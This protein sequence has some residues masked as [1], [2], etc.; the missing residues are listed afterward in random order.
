[1]DIT[2][3]LGFPYLMPN[4]AQKH[5]TLNS[6]LTQLDAIIGLALRSRTLTLQPEAPAPGDTYLLP[7]GAEGTEWESV[8]PGNLVIFRGDAWMP[9]PAPAGL[10]AWVEDEGE[11][12][13]RS[14]GGWVPVIPSELPVL[15]IQTSADETN[16]L[17]V[18]S[19]AVLFSHDD[20]APGSGDVRQFLNRAD[21]AK[22]ASVIFETGHT[23]NAEIGLAGSSHLDLRTSPDGTAFNTG[24][25]LDAATG[26]VSFP[27]GFAEGLT[28][29]SQLGLR[30]ATGLIDDDTAVTI[31]FGESVF[32][33]V[34]LA[35]PNALSS[36]PVVLFFA[37]MA[38]S[39]ALTPLFSEG[40]SFTTT[41]GELTGTTGTDGGINF[42][43]TSDGRFLIENRRGFG[44]GYTVYAFR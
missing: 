1:M 14:T 34:L 40:H 17:A 20:V 28:I 3:R 5:V 37:R 35:V 27:S 15:G 33:S 18:K 8:G 32:G 10:I 22:T 16:R 38:S 21:A 36:G 11:L 12:I 41:T 31:D 25:R 7:D 13:A 26:K 44:V 23:A 4:Q 43:A 42:S 29:L 39:P 24:L 2:A 6:A 9:L 30:H 19:D